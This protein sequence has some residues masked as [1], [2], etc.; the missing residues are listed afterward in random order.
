M[1]TNISTATNPMHAVPCHHEWEVSA[2]IGLA[3]VAIFA[4][5]IN[6]LT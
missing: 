1:T 5:D 3:A 6:L 2:Y 4:D